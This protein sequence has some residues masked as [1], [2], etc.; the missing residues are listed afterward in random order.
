MAETKINGR[1][2]I[3]QIDIVGAGTFKPV[4]CLTTN[5]LNTQRDAIDATSKCGDAMVAGDA[6]VQT[7]EGSGF[8]IDQTG[9][10]SKESYDTLYDL[11]KNK[12][13]FQARFGRADNSGTYFHGEAIVTTLNLTA[14]DKE[15]MTFDFT[16]TPTAPPF[17][18]LEY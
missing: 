9:T 8:A 18:K 2:I 11:L 5:N 6:V 12:T 15:L 16:L 17:D 3:V 4:A 1:D 10:P 14:A 7:L 13:A